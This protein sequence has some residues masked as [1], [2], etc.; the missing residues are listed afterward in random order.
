MSPGGAKTLNVTV[1]SNTTFCDGATE[2]HAET[3]ER[4]WTTINLPLSNA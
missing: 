4:G 2:R 1:F 3:V